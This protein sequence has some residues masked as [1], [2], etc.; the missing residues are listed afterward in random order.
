MFADKN[1]WIPANLPKIKGT[2]NFVVLHVISTK[3]GQYWLF[4]EA[5]LATDLRSCEDYHAFMVTIHRKHIC[6]IG[7]STTQRI[8]TILINIVYKS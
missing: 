2:E 5:L 4:V 1:F 7:S 8:N 6:W 3:A